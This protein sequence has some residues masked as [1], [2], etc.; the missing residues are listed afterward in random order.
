MSGQGEVPSGA[1]AAGSPPGPQARPVVRRIEQR[2]ARAPRRPPGQ[3][4]ALGFLALIA[5]GTVLLWTPM[6]RAGGGHAAFMDAL[7]TAT[8]ATCVV[9]LTVVDTGTHWT[10]FGQ[11]VILLLIQVGGLGIMAGA[12]LIGIAVSRRLGL[13]TR[14]MAAAET[15]T[16]DLSDVRRVVIGVTTISLTIEALVAV[17][18]TLRF[19]L[20]YG[21]PWRTAA[22]EGLFHA[23]SSFNNAGFT[24]FPTGLLPF[25][26]D[27]WVCLP[28]DAAV[29]LGGLGFPVLFEVFRDRA[30]RT[31]GARR[32]FSPNTRTALGMTAGLLVFGTVAVLL[33][34]RANPLTLGQLDPGARLLASFTQSVMP[35]SAGLNTLDYGV[36]TAATLLI[37]MALMF[38]G[39]SSASTAGGVKVGTT[40]IAATSVWAQ[41]RGDDDTVLARRSVPAGVV[42]QAYALIFVY[43]ATLFVG[44]FAVMVLSDASSGNIAF[45]VTSALTTTGLSTGLTGS[46]PEPALVVLTVLMYIGRLGPVSLGAALALRNH[47]RRFR[48]PEGRPNVG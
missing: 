5:I 12:S 20:G 18:L 26:S 39:G 38:V 6:A 34:E 44:I 36:M 24:L 9:G 13:R 8:S 21:Q 10:H 33:T 48:Y 45:E 32:G 41:V 27:P 30:R 35:R 22:W 29:I 28:I 11:V 31:R 25:V 46:L 4:V 16:V 47:Q 2:L 40:A 3:V 15:R 1:P 7:F 19:A 17:L 23:V 37:S 43:G 14:V 42:R